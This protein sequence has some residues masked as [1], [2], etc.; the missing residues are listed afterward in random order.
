MKR[1]TVKAMI[2]G[3]LLAIVEGT[4]AAPPPP[5][6]PAPAFDTAV[7][8]LAGQL[9]PQSVVSALN[10]LGDSP[11]GFRIAGAPAEKAAADYIA[12][13]FTSMG[14]SNVRKEPV[15]VD[16]WIMRG[17]S[18][19]VGDRAMV[20]SQFPGVPGTTG[21][22]S[23]PIVYVGQGRVADYVGKNV[24]GKLV[25]IDIE[26]DDF[27]WNVQGHEAKIQGAV[28]VVFTT[29]STTGTAIADP[30]ALYSEESKWGLNDP[31]AV[32]ISGNDGAWLK[33]RIAMGASTAT[34]L[35]DV[36]VKMHNF[37]SPSKGGLAYN[38]VGEIPGTD[39]TAKA[40]LIGAHFDAYFRPGL[41]NTGSVAQVLT[42]AKAMKMS[43]TRFK[44]TVIFLAQT[45]E[46]FGYTD[47][48]YDYL[49][50]VWYAATITHASGKA[51]P[52]TGPNGRVALFID[53]EESPQAGPFY[54]VPTPDL[55]PWFDSV[56]AAWARELLPFGYIAYDGYIVYH[57]GFAMTAAGVPAMVT[58]AEDDSFEGVTSTNQDTE[59]LIDYSYLAKLAKFYHRLM[60]DASATLLPHDLDAQAA[61]LSATISGADLKAAGAN[62]ATVDALVAAVQ[63]YKTATAGYA[64][65][66]PSIPSS[67][68]ATVNSGL[69]SIERHWYGNLT[70]ID[71]LDSTMIY[72]HQ[73]TLADIQHLQAAI[74]LLQRPTVNKSAVLAE[75]SQV[76]LTAT[77][78]TF[79]PEAYTRLLQRHLPDYYLLAWGGGTVKQPWRADIMNQ[80]RQVQNGD[81]AG[82]LAELNVVLASHI[83]GAT[84]PGY[85][86]GT[87][88]TFDGLN[89]RLA[90][91]TAALNTMRPMVDN[92]R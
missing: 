82:A 33:N 90:N 22:L 54:G 17:A 65:R 44:R 7:D 50:G 21:P 23:A 20:A 61:H 10:S 87:T 62:P 26:I 83:N 78:M 92:L 1:L 8:T 25:L 55:L 40:I 41:D 68:W 53:L 64:A 76:G 42:I 74:T 51:D 38:V 71:A 84:V 32:F 35:S 24:A 79:S 28:G 3:A 15:P 89:Q 19:Q 63:S 34:M 5:P 13:Q 49:A 85:R 69:F 47:T 37:S 77:G 56:A 57:D 67:R 27:W 14:L 18:L 12:A 11:L 30:N 36:E 86:A 9:Y 29:G 39:P 73:Q 31:P 75:L 66:K 58:V 91:I 60:A 80:V 46:E 4:I 16:A 48:E 52:W 59:A 43:N 6:P 2:A 70:G 45:A 88:V 81:Y 72:P